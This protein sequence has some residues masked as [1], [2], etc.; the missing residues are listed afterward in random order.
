MQACTRDTERQILMFKKIL[1]KIQSV[2]DPH[3]QER[4]RVIG[5]CNKR[6]E[7][8]TD[9]DGYVYWWPDGSPH[10]HLASHHLRW[11]ADELDDRN[12][13]FDEEID[14]YFKNKK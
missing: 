7:F 13:A 9:V 8:I 6:N 2:L 4:E 12:A 10:G 1:Q 3:K 11:I 5:F 14:N